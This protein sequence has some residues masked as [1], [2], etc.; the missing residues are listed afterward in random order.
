[1]MEI[2]NWMSNNVGMTILILLVAM[3]MATFC[4]TQIIKSIRGGDIDYD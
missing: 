3:P 1:M 4:L 2:L